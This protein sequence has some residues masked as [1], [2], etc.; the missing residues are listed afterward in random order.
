VNL[1]ADPNRTQPIDD[2]D[3]FAESYHKPISASVSVDKSCRAEIPL[4]SSNAKGENEPRE[5]D[6]L[7]G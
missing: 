2:R 1:S 6:E 7:D 4:D 5:R 3:F